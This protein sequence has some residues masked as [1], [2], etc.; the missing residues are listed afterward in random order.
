MTL[1]AGTYWYEFSD[2]FRD[3]K[4][5]MNMDLMK[6]QMFGW[7]VV[8]IVVY[9][10]LFLNDLRTD[11]HSLPL[12]PESIVILTGLSQIGYLAGKGVAGVKP[13]TDQ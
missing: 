6:F 12:V 9:S 11:I 3:D 5:P 4:N 8:A 1:G 7:T 2:L 10:W 13:R